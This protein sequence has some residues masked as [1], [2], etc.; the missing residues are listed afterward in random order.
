MDDRPAWE[1]ELELVGE[2]DVDADGELLPDR[3]LVTVAN[4]RKQLEIITAA[5]KARREMRAPDGRELEYG[6]WLVAEHQKWLDRPR[7]LTT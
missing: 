5:V 6:A 2:G 4:W 7:T 3:E 1:L